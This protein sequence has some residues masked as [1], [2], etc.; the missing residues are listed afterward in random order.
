V[1]CSVLQCV[2]V[3]CSVFECVVVGETC[4]DEALAVFA[5]NHH[6]IV[7]RHVHLGLQ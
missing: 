4:R 7:L 6:E 3:R 1:C 2:A 5:E